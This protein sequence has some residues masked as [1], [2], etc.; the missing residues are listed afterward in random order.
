MILCAATVATSFL[1]IHCSNKTSSCRTEKGKMIHKNQVVTPT[2]IFQKCCR[3]MSAFW[4]CCFIKVCKYGFQ[5][6]NTGCISSEKTSI[7]ANFCNIFQVYNNFTV[8][9]PGNSES[10][11]LITPISIKTQK[12]KFWRFFFKIFAQPEITESCLLIPYYSNISIFIVRENEISTHFP[13]H[14]VWQKFFRKFK[15]LK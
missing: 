1:T 6:Q 3:Y 10:A 4:S 13:P 12:W 5:K 9:W 14:T 8:K 11:P 15:K 7:L 2:D